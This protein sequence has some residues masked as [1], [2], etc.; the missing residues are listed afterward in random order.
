M[1]DGKLTNQN[2]RKTAKNDGK[3]IA[4]KKK[5]QEKGKY[6]EGQKS[7]PHMQKVRGT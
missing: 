3:V 6:K 2:N 4:N 7:F 1:R 5:K